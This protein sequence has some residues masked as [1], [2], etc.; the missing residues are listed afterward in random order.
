MINY[1]VF[2]NSNLLHYCCILTPLSRILQSWF[3]VVVIVVSGKIILVNNSYVLRLFQ[4]CFL[5]M[6]VFILKIQGFLNDVA[7]FSQEV[8]YFLV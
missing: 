3:V 5:L 2:V 4:P 7:A 6:T 1:V 8:K